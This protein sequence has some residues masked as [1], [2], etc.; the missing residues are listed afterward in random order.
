LDQYEYGLLH[1]GPKTPTGIV[2]LDA[3]AWAN[4]HPSLFQSYLRDT[5]ERGFVY[6]VRGVERK[7]FSFF[8]WAVPYDTWGWV[9]LSLSLV[10][11]TVVSKGKWLDAFGALLARQSYSSL[12]KNKSVILILF[13]AIV[14]TCG[15]ESIISSSLILPPPIIVARRLKDLV[16]SGYGIIGYDKSSYTATIFMT[17][18][19]ENISY[20]SVN[21]HPFVP[22]TAQSNSKHTLRLLAGCNVTYLMAPGD[23]D[24]MQYW[25]NQRPLLLGLRCHVVKETRQAQ[26]FLITYSGYF[27]STVHT[28]VISFQESGILEMFYKFYDYST[29]LALRIRVEKKRYADERAE[30]PLKLRD[31]K[32]LSIFIAWGGLLV[33]ASLVFLIECFSSA[34]SYLSLSVHYNK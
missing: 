23:A 2:T 25:I 10:G 34:Y 13:A 11:L 3:L 15:Y 33:G 22:N 24:T 17:L 27:P 5:R 29:N 9:L 6:C 26:A 20:S 19:I 32:I 7:S 31:P 1:T 4:R 21:E 18:Q 14:L 28:L 12:D 8:F 16:D 30:V